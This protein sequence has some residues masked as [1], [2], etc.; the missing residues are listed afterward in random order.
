MT[1]PALPRLVGVRA[2][3]RVPSATGARWDVVTVGWLPDSPRLWCDT[4]PGRNCEHIRAVREAI[5][6]PDERTP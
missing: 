1:D 3:L 6:P 5:H 4:C 2:V